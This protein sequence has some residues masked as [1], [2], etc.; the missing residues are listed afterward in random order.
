MGEDREVI[1]GLVRLAHLTHCQL[2]ALGFWL[3]GFTQDEIAQ[4]EG[5]SQQAVS[6]QI[7]RAMAEL[8]IVSASM[9]LGFQSC[10]D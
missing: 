9:D 10:E 7:Q 2:V 8:R 1:I 4:I 6:R 3:A 5:V